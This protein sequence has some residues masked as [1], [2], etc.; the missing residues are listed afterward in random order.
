MKQIKKKLAAC[1]AAAALLS[2][3][4]ITAHAELPWLEIEQGRHYSTLAELYSEDGAALHVPQLNTQKPNPTLLITYEGSADR[5][6][7]DYTLTSTRNPWFSNT[8]CFPDGEPAEP[9][10]KNKAT[11][12]VEV[13]ADS[14]EDG[15]H[16]AEIVLE[17][18][19]ESDAF[20]WY[21]LEAQCKCVNTETGTDCTVLR[22]ELHFS[23]PK[24]EDVTI[25]DYF[26]T[27]Q[28]GITQDTFS[29]SLYAKTG[30]SLLT[31]PKTVTE[32]QFN[33]SN[34]TRSVQA[35]KAGITGKIPVLRDADPLKQDTEG[36]VPHTKHVY[37][38][39]LS[40]YQAPESEQLTKLKSF[41]VSATKPYTISNFIIPSSAKE[42]DA[43]Y[44][45]VEHHGNAVAA[46]V[47]CSVSA[48]S[49]PDGCDSWS[50]NYFL[51][52]AYPLELF[53]NSESAMPKWQADPDAAL[54]MTVSLVTGFANEGDPEEWAAQNPKLTGSAT[55]T[56]YGR[57][58]P[59]EDLPQRD[60]YTGDISC[61]D[62][63]DV[64]DAVMLARYLNQ[65]KGVSPCEAGLFRADTD[66][67][68]SVT[69]DDLTCSC[70]SLRGR[71]EQH[72]H[73]AKPLPD[74]R[75][76]LFGMLYVIL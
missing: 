37:L 68:G 18:F 67:D 52:T 19:P 14:T 33:R 69:T 10:E 70:K 17:P 5:V 2:S 9:E 36:D 41:T 50:Q 25:Q 49:D 56:I 32:Y 63:V 39:G 12:N 20:H 65:D 62:R 24:D 59:P 74:E 58:L 73:T 61:D 71:S 43:Y 27:D 54:S 26:L 48:P 28:S 13:P 21:D 42:Y 53:R 76:R 3:Q 23:Y 46:V 15:I 1:I 31:K 30:D 44:F 4:M 64:S 57:K 7:A 6:Q 29:V 55:F 40:K 66:L 75:E 35:K 16:T 38:S 34:K 8:V 72:H 47:N 60:A 51:D 22:T 11:F 45:A